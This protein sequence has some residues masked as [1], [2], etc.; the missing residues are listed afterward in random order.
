[1][2][3]P[4]YNWKIAGE[5]G[6][7]IMNTGGPIFS[8]TL[9]RAGFF[10][11]VYAEYP[12]LIRGGHNAYQVAV[13]LDP[14][15]APYR[16]IDQL[17][18]L[19]AYTI[20]MHQDEVREGGIVLYDALGVKF[21][22]QSS[23]LKTTTQTSKVTNVRGVVDNTQIPTL[24]G[25]Y[26]LKK[27]KER[28]VLRNDIKFIPIDFERIAREAGGDKIMKNTAAVGA[29]LALFEKKVTAD[30]QRKKLRLLEIAD[31]VVV[32]IFKGKGEGIVKINQR[33]L[34]VGYNSISNF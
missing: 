2:P 28:T 24:T 25:I 6:Y 15:D 13:S 30:G 7:G 34:E 5:A 1:M 31:K 12:S 32:D 19:D 27:A 9:I 18:A 11:F 10:V 33:V 29:S 23:N 17:V 20:I 21:K 8:K 3:T 16:E 14:I 26:S 22:T 4:L